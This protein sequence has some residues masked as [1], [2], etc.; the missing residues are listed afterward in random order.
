MS[1]RYFTN[2]AATGSGSLVDAVKNAAPGDVVRP[3]PAVFERG[4]TIEIALASQLNVG[5]NLTLD[6]SPFRVRLDGGGLRLCASVAKQVVA[7][8]TAV[9]FVAGSYQFSGGGVRVETSAAATFNRCRFAGCKANYGGAVYAETGSSLTLNDCV[10]AGCAGTSGIGGI[11]A[12]GDVALNGCVVA[13][14]VAPTGSDVSTASA[15]T[16]VFRNSFLGRS[17]V[18]IGDDSGCVVGVADSAIGFV[19]PPPDNLTL[20]DWNANLWR[21]WDLRLLDDGASAPSPHRDAGNPAFASEFDF[22]G[23]RRG[24]RVDGAT[25]CSPGAYETIQADL[26]WI[27][28]AVSQA[29]LDAAP[30]DLKLVDV[31]VGESVSGTIAWTLPEPGAEIRAL[32]RSGGSTWRVS[33][34]SPGDA[35][36]RSFSGV[37]LG[38]RVEYSFQV[39][40]ASGVK[41]AWSTIAFVGEANGGDPVWRVE[42]ERSPALADAAGWASSRFASTS[43]TTAP[44]DANSAFIGVSADFVDAADAPELALAVGG[45]RRVGLCGG[46]LR[47]FSLGLAAELAAS[48]RVF[49]DVETFRLAPN[50]NVDASLI[51]RS[52]AGSGGAPGA[53]IASAAFYALAPADARYGTLKAARTSGGAT[54]LDGD[55]VCETFST[56]KGGDGSTYAIGTAPGATIRCQH[57]LC[58][59]DFASGR[60]FANPVVVELYGAAT[61]TA[62]RTGTTAED[63]G[64]AFV[65]DLSDATEA[66]LTLDGQTFFGDVPDLAATLSGTAKLDGRGLTTRSLT[67]AAGA[68]LNVENAEVATRFL[69]TNAGSRIVG[70][71]RVQLA[72][73]AKW[74]NNGATIN[75]DGA[76][77]YDASTNDVKISV[78]FDASEIRGAAVDGSYRWTSPSLDSGA[79]RPIF[80]K[81]G[82]NAQGKGDYRT[83]YDA[84]VPV[85]DRAEPVYET[86]ADWNGETLKTVVCASPEA[87]WNFYRVEI[88]SIITV[89]G[90][91]IYV[92]GQTTRYFVFWNADYEPEPTYYYCGDAN[93]SFARDSDWSLTPDGVAKFEGAPTSAGAVFFVSRSARL[94]D[95]PSDALQISVA[96]PSVVDVYDAF[97]ERLSSVEARLVSVGVP[98]PS[99]PAFCVGNGGTAGVWTPCD[100]ATLYRIEAVDG[101][102]TGLSTSSR[103]LEPREKEIKNW[104]VRVAAPVYGGV[105]N[106]SPESVAVQPFSEL[107]EKPSYADATS[108]ATFELVY[109]DNFAGLRDASIWR[110]GG[111][112]ETPK[113]VAQSF[114]GG[115]FTDVP[116]TF[117]EYVY[118]VRWTP[119]PENVWLETVLAPWFIADGFAAVVQTNFITTPSRAYETPTFAARIA[120]KS[121]GELLKRQDV[122][123]ISYSLFE[124]RDYWRTRSERLA[125]GSDGGYWRRDVEIP[126]A[127]VRDALLVDPNFWSLDEIGANFVFSPDDGRPFFPGPGSYI[128]RAT[129]E[130]TRGKRV[131]VD[132]PTQ[133][134]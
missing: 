74:E 113:L 12:K 58:A 26:F 91:K 48:A 64:G 55:Y 13:G 14:C 95:F 28:G 25:S 11:Y 37:A 41:S 83:I 61:A 110:S 1:T 89:G 69:T 101:S 7:T 59:A 63:F 104:R 65:V 50:S 20:D 99:S 29:E 15:A 24:R 125:I 81:Y 27:G 31:E 94:R 19:A 33:S 108:G 42:T 92:E 71:G 106:W 127:A 66:T 73:G 88:P 36:S 96:F 134:E 35:T 17:N 118:R 68:T 105:E 130:T 43:G 126:A 133:V 56:L 87:G 72:S 9:D 84:N 120:K 32:I 60:L 49:V 76:E 112:D 2:N 30:Q 53:T 97:G 6:A 45:F 115:E 38:Q 18:T 102:A 114:K 82:F 46:R 5:K 107:R 116:E 23:N 54:V 131:V 123:K 93:G 80:A 39:V 70:Q 75:N 8:F 51:V 124:N 119:S 117:D 109:A 129:L 121:N 86:D 77:S 47:A 67:L 132:F 44:T 34:A 122:A 85:V 62:P 128:V 78:A 79:L 98:A 103:W 57:F 100:G 4:A 52:D 21:D 90:F 22:D 10:V 3:D 16:V 111:G 40:F